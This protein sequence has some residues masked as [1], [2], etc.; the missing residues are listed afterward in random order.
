L[1]AIIEER[2]TDDYGAAQS[3][4]KREVGLRTVVILGIPPL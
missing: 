3:N 1:S 4:E 2:R